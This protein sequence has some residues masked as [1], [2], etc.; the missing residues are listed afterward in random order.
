MKMN[1]M[2][3]QYIF[4]NFFIKLQNRKDKHYKN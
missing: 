4:N 3:I 1:E 2:K